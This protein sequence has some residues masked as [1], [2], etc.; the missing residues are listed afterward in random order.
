MDRPIKLWEFL[1]G[2]LT[3]SI[4]F[5]TIIYNCGVMN[6]KN[7]LR[8]TTLENNFGEHIKDAKAETIE[9]GKKLEE[10]KNGLFDIKMLLQMKQDKK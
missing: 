1:A 8:I 6:A 4:A 3:L 10:V 9:N 2:V 5:G 7:E